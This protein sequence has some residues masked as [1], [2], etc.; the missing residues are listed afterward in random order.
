M[1]SPGVSCS[2]QGVLGCQDPSRMPSW[3][4]LRLNFMPVIKSS[5]N[6]QFCVLITQFWRCSA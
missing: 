6:E 3:E 4:N 2:P 1:P 5:K